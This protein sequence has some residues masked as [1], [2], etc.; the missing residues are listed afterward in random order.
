MALS[1]KIYFAYGFQEFALAFMTNLGVQFI[2]FFL[3]DTALIPAAI[4]ATIL[5]IGR[6]VDTIDVPIIGMIVEKTNLPWG[7]FRSWLFIAPPLEI[8]FTMLMFS[9]FNVSMP[10]KIAYL[11]TA[12]ILA[13]VATNFTSTA[14]FSL[15]PTFTSDQNERAKLSA[16]RGQGAALSMVVKGA[17]VVPLIAF[18]GGGNDAKGYFLTVIVFGVIVLFGL[19]WLAILAKDYDKPG[20]NKGQKSLTIKEMLVQLGTNKPLLILLLSNTFLQ[21]ASNVLI[22]FALYYFRYVVG[23]LMLFSIYL[24]ISFAGGFIGATISNYISKRFD[25]KFSYILGVAFWFLGMLLVYLFAGNSAWLFIAFVTIAQFGYG[26]SNATVPAFF[27]D[28]ADYGE[29]KT[30]KSFKALNMSLVIFPIKFGLFIGG[31][32]AAYALAF[33]GFAAGTKDPH[34]IEG[35]RMM[36]AILPLLVSILAALPMFFYP[37]NKDD[38]NKIQLENRQRISAAH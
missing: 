23:N 27:S 6:I 31:S 14:R 1:R 4:V 20:A 11:S 12:Y 35:I 5:S 3:T 17:I 9:N 38:I 10:L 8:L 36:I 25:K 37:L 32:I 21:A 33:I 29:W 16:R 19:Y 30:G 2:A 7:K 28:T 13:Y 34:V 15:L 22:G 24:P 26:I 18:L